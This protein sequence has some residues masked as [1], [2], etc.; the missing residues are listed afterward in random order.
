M[1]IKGLN[2][3]LSVILV[4]S[5]ASCGTP[6]ANRE[7]PSTQSSD[8]T[9]ATIGSDCNQ[10]TNADNASTQSETESAQAIES[11]ANAIEL[12]TGAQ[13]TNETQTTKEQVTQKQT[14]AATVA[15]SPEI[16]AN[17]VQ[18]NNEVIAPITNEVI[19]SNDFKLIS[20]TNQK[21]GSENEFIQYLKT[22]GATYV[23]STSE[24][25]AIINTTC[26]SANPGVNLCFSGNVDI[27]AL[28]NAFPQDLTLSKYIDMNIRRVE[29]NCIQLG[30]SSSYYFGAKFTWWT[31]PTEEAAVDSLVKNM[32]PTLNQGTTTYDKIK[33]VHDYIC[34][35]A[36]YSDATLNG[37]ADDFS[38]YDAL[39]GKLAVCQGYA[40][41]FQKFM[42]AMGIESQIVKGDI[43]TP[44]AVGS[45]AWNVVKLNGAWYSVDCTW[46][47][48][49]DITIHD[50]FLL[51][52]K[53]YPYGITGGISLAPSKYIN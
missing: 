16:V 15:S 28:I 18:K 17:V 9:L 50:Y 43:N 11:A 29:F 53:E 21:F 4:L 27:D 32:L 33:N 30:D 40:L 38:A 52:A 25:I 24:A 42:D 44:L 37:T 2:L 10:K 49:F 51:G 34:N 47:G 13:N 39:Y 41:A 48:Q 19:P 7:L 5:L 1:K 31:T 23:A 6:N 14:E 12:T 35:I 3:F 36:N 20:L 22:N 8:L 46:D 45:H 26:K